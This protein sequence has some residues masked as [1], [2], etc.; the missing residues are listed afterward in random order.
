MLLLLN[1]LYRQRILPID[2]T[3]VG[4]E[5]SGEVFVLESKG[6]EIDVFV[7]VGPLG[8]RLYRRRHCDENYG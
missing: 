1:S 6:F 7:I 4:T 3:I 5:Q 2:S 8:K